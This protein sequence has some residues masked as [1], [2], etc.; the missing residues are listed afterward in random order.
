M[1]IITDLPLVLLL[2]TLLTGSGQPQE[3][4]DLDGEVSIFTI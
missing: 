2:C 4:L 3:D 1:N